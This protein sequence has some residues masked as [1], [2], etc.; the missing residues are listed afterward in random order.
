MIFSLLQVGLDLR[1]VDDVAGHV[2]LDVGFG[3][4]RGQDRLPGWKR[5]LACQITIEPG[6]PC[7]RMKAVRV[8]I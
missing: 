4:P 7:R 8:M 1:G 6:A 2:A 5:L 3:A